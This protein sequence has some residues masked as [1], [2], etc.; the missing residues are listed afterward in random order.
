MILSVLLVAAAMAW[1]RAHEHVLA[2]RWATGQMAMLAWRVELDT[3]SGN[4]G[5]AA[6]ARVVLGP[7]KRVEGAIATWSPACV[8]DSELVLR[9]VPDLL[10]PTTGDHHLL[11]I[12]VD[13]HPVIRN[14]PTRDDCVRS[15]P[16]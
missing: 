15:P 3:F 8:Q 6:T 12:W 10:P 2:Y 13:A 9:T 16:E 14:H 5:I 4:P 1:S 7:L 11:N